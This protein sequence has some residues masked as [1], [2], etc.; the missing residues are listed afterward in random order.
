MLVAPSDCH[1]SHRRFT[2][3]TY[4]FSKFVIL[5]ALAAQMLAGCAPAPTAL[6]TPSSTN[7]SPPTLV[8]TPIPPSPTP[9]PVSPLGATALEG[10]I[11]VVTMPEGLEVVVNGVG[12]GEL[13]K[14]ALL[15]G[16]GSQGDVRALYERA[17]AALPQG[18][19]IKEMRIG[20]NKHWGTL[21]IGSDGLAYT[22]LDKNGLPMQAL[23][24]FGDPN[25][26]LAAS[27]LM[28]VGEVGKIKFAQENN[29]WVVL[30][31][32]EGRAYWDASI[33]G[34]GP[35]WVLAGELDGVTVADARGLVAIGNNTYVFNEAVGEF[36]PVEVSGDYILADGIVHAWN[37]EQ[38]Q[39]LS[40]GIEG[41]VGFEERQ[42]GALWVVGGNGEVLGVKLEDGRVVN[43]EMAAKELDLPSA[44]GQVYTFGK[45]EINLEL[46]EATTGVNAILIR[47]KNWKK[48]TGEMQRIVDP[49]GMNLK[50]RARY[51]DHNEGGIYVE[52]ISLGHYGEFGDSGS[53]F[54]LPITTDSGEVIGHSIWTAQVFVVESYN[55]AEPAKSKFGLLN[56]V[57]RVKTID[58]KVYYCIEGDDLPVRVFELE[59]ARYA[60]G[61]QVQIKVQPDRVG[62]DAYFLTQRK[63]DG[64]QGLVDFLDNYYRVKSDE[65]ANLPNGGEPGLVLSAGSIPR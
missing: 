42:D 37:E 15:L 19:G 32:E 20:V 51:F 50:A 13:A 5:L 23:N 63:G 40:T 65:L 34:K 29:G 45:N 38:K 24:P 33:A 41:A 54:E 12:E 16:E 10:A 27:G 60:V 43:A 18:V 46:R 4:N 52:G 21:I 59:A 58:N 7:A 35:G 62:A 30:T 47:G 44:E 48:L 8:A 49:S 53:P 57:L 2:V 55:S 11:S 39:F 22:W 28:A 1:L 56:V 31:I 26:E 6:P 25:N 14:A 9:F 61:K 36:R 64:F 3:G 17:Q